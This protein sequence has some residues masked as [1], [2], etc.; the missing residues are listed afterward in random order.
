M[1]ACIYHGGCSDGFA[2]AWVVRLAHK[3]HE[4]QVEFFPGR[5][6][7]PLPEFSERP[8]MIYVVDFSWPWD[9]MVKLAARTDC[10]V[11]LDHHQTALD[12]RQ[13]DP[14]SSP[15]NMFIVLDM[16]RSGAMLTW[17]YFFDDPPPPVFLYVQDRDL[18]RW[19]LENSREVSSL[20]LATPMSWDSW[21]ELMNADAGQL[22]DRA[23]GAW[24][25][26]QATIA[27]VIQHAHWCGMGSERLGTRRVFPIAAAPYIVGSS[28]AE[29]MMD[30][31]GSDMAAYYIQ[32][33]DGDVQYGFRSRNGVTVHDF[34]KSLSST[35][36]G[37]PSAAGCT[38][39]GIYH[40]RTPSPSPEV[41]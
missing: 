7:M 23:H 22:A 21:T 37:H 3:D 13:A 30:E 8:S 16:E 11:W 2:A 10:L 39:P 41:R 6:G 40:W 38:L 5:Y 25:F 28:L 9:Q 35:G 32:K 17:D 18:W 34:A 4:E 26:E 27:S 15:D 24:V 31:F 19:E 14:G 29:A 1:I 33:P 20:I 36:G 12:S